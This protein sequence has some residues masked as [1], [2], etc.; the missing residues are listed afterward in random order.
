MTAHLLRRCYTL[1]GPFTAAKV[2]DNIMNSLEKQSSLHADIA[3]S[4][5]DRKNGEKKYGG[6]DNVQKSTR[7]FHA[8]ST[9]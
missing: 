5:I 8:N 4:L 7:V 1:A 3:F 2:R 9:T 6:H